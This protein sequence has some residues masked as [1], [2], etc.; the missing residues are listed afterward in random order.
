MTQAIT[1]DL[2]EWI[3]AQAKA[4]YPA[5]AVLKSMVDAG[6]K[7]DIATDALESATPAHL[8]CAA[9]AR[10]AAVP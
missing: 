9:A 7:E 10:L 3:V 1:N 4:G 8:A 6:W 5:E 2:R